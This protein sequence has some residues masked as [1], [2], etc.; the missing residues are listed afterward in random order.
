VYYCNLQARRLRELNLDR[1]LDES[2]IFAGGTPS[3]M[4]RA[5]G[6]DAPR[7]LDW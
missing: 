4:P 6:R 2:E 7:E 1:P 5:A 3:G